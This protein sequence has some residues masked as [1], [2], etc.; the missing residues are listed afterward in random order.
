M[1]F[2]LWRRS[3][4][5]VEWHAPPGSAPRPDPLDHI[6]LDEWAEYASDE[7]PCPPDKS[8]AADG[9][10]SLGEKLLAVLADEEASLVPPSAGDMT[11]EEWNA[12]TEAEREGFRRLQLKRVDP[13]FVPR[14]TLN[15]Q[16]N[17][18]RAARVY[19]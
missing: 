6:D 2:H 15:T 11:Q 17:G 12:L 14:Y 7:V 13:R 19:R 5:K 16:R 9:I 10:G 18:S 3:D 4:R 1:R 8:S